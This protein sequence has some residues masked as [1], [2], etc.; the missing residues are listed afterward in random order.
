MNIIWT[1]CTQSECIMYTYFIETTRIQRE[2]VKEWCSEQFFFVDRNIKNACWM[3]LHF[4]IMFWLCICIAFGPFELT[5]SQ[6]ATNETQP[7]NSEE[8]QKNA[9]WNIF[10][11]LNLLTS[12][13]M[14]TFVHAQWTSGNVGEAEGEGDG[15]IIAY[16]EEILYTSQEWARIVYIKCARTVYYC[17]MTTKIRINETG[18]QI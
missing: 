16:S 9:T 3:L 6:M 4:K 11:S 14:I 7:T 17:I 2:A 5:T 1:E 10:S 13:I 8:Q 15:N 12:C 18:Q